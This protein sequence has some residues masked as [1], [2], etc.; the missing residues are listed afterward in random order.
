M[1]GSAITAQAFEAVVATLPLGSVGDE[2]ERT[3]TGGSSIWLDSSSADTLFAER[4]QR[5]DFS[6]TILRPAKE[7][8]P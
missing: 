3:A 7:T 4:R 1:I 2:R 8:P 5:E 6:D